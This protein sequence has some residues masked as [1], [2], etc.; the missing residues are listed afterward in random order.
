MTLPPGDIVLEYGQPLRIL[1][2]LNK[3]MIDANYPGKN[4]SDIVFTYNEKRIMEKEYITIINETAVE[5]YIEKPPPEDTMYYCK[6]R[7]T[8]EYNQQQLLAVCLNKVVI[9]CKYC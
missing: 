6:L 8:D 9:G 4:A 3:T 5:M 1:C 2:V 7:L